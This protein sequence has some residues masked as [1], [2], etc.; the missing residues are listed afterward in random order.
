MAATDIGNCGTALELCN[1]P[2][3]RRQPFADKMRL[4]ARTKKALDPAKKAIA[5]FL[6][7]CRT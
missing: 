3:K 1:N 5:V 7:L 4:V 6:A 2:L